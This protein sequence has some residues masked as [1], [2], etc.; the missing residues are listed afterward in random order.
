MRL[1][2]FTDYSLRILIY[3]AARGGER[4]TIEDAALHFGISMAHLKKV[5]LHLSR[6]GFLHGN[7]G[8]T[9][10]FEL[11]RAPDLINIGAVI[12]S[13]E[14]D[15]GLFECFLEGNTCAITRP[16]RLPTIGHEAL[17]AFLGVF[18]RYTLADVLLRP[19]LFVTPS[20]GALQPVRRFP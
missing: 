17:H 6:A 8:R 5:V 16:C 7:R 15:F 19:D 9:G 10:G 4:T 2:K 13:T 14:P 18:D 3:V 1:T 12:R 11:A 20:S